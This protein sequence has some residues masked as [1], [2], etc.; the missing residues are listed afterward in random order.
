MKII[1]VINSL[2]YRG[3]AQV[4][5]ASLCEE[6]ATIST[7]K[8]HVIVLYDRFDASFKNIIALKGIV[9]HSLKKKGRLDFNVAKEFKKIVEDVNPDII[10]YHLPFLMTYFLSFG[11]KKTNWKLVKTFHSI[12]NKDTNRFE[13]FLEREYA[14]KGLI[15]FIGIS[16]SI[17]KMSKKIYPNSITRTIYNGI[18]PHPA[19]NAS[20]KN[21]DFIIIASFS[22]VKNHAFLINTFEKYLLI[23]PNSK[24]LCVGDG[25][26]LNKCKK[27]VKNKK[28]DKNVIFI[29]KKD[30][31]FPLLNSSRA[32]V[33]ASTREGNPISILEAMSMG[34][35]IIAP[36]VGGVPDIVENM[37]NGILYEANNENEL[38]QAFIT[39]SG[40]AIYNTIKANNLIKSKQYLIKYSASQY[41]SFFMDLK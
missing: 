18:K 7:E 6:L 26:L 12:P 21:Y 33:L 1:E 34:L 13:I 9:F 35:P 19:P 8:I 5:F 41:L 40:S 32:F 29:G 30:N 2:S 10:N 38:L 37:V 22:K 27:I 15:S 3:G 23:N 16:E 31:V 39:I 11:F 20:N 17:S 4:F 24:L 36:K 28:M 25:R 14:K